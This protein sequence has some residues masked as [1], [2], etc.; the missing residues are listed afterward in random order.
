MT[1]QWLPVVSQKQVFLNGRR[2]SRHSLGLSVRGWQAF[3][4][5]VLE[6]MGSAA[7]D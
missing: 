2:S 3:S 1:M 4:L 5:A 6:G 7:E